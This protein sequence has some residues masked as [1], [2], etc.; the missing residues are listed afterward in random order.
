[1]FALPKHIL[2]FHANKIMWKRGWAILKADLLNY[3]YL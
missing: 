3:T 2:A 1:M